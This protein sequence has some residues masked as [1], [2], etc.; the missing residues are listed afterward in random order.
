MRKAVLFLLG[1]LI[2][3]FQLHAQDRVIS[4]RVFDATGN[5]ISN[6]TVIVKGSSV[7]TTSKADGSFTLTVPASA[8]ALVI[9]SVGMAPEEVNINGK[10]SVDVSLKAGDTNLQEVVVTGYTTTSR[11]KSTVAASV[12]GAKDISNV[13]MTNVN[14]ILQGKATGLTVMSTSGQPGSPGCPEVLITVSPV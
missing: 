2:L 11:N 3:A 4:G 8:R 5:P 6:A 9:S 10:N 7:G 14:D 13:P 12:V 1:C